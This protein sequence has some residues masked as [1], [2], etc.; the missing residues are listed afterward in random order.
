MHVK[1]FPSDK[2]K[3][4]NIVILNILHGHTHVDSNQVEL[5]RPLLISTTLLPCMG[6]LAFQPRHPMMKD[7]LD[8]CEA[9]FKTYG[10]LAFDTLSS[11]QHFNKWVQEQKAEDSPYPL[12][13]DGVGGQMVFVGFQLGSKSSWIW[14]IDFVP[15]DP[16]VCIPPHPC[17]Q[18]AHDE[19]TRSKPAG[20]AWEWLL[21]GSEHYASRCPSQEQ[22]AF[23]VI[24]NPAFLHRSQ[25]LCRAATSSLK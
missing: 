14:L 6:K 4:E 17:R 1:L 10:D 16:I 2:K 18:D 21:S 13:A 9:S 22:K 11:P 25:S 8:H 23:P 20:K 3:Q 12:G 5:K 24:I 15:F 7:Y 19:P